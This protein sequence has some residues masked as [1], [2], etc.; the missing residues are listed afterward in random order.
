MAKEKDKKPLTKEEMEKFI[1]IVKAKGEEYEKHL[2]AQ[3]ELQNNTELKKDYETAKKL[4]EKMVSE[5]FIKEEVKKP[6]V[7][8]SA[9]ASLFSRVATKQ[10]TE[11]KD[12]DKKSAMAKFNKYLTS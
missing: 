8:E 4:H 2:K 11:V 6:V 3:E 7:D 12:D 5:G 10:K 9:I 1:E